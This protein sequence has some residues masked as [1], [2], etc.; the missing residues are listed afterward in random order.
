MITI[1][2]M[3]YRLVCAVL[4]VFTLIICTLLINSFI[5]DRRLRTIRRVLKDFQSSSLS[6]CPNK[7][8]N[9]I[10][11]PMLNMTPNVTSSKVTN[12]PPEVPS[13]SI[14][15]MKKPNAIP[16]MIRRMVVTSL[17]S[18][19]RV[20][21]WLR[22]LSINKEQNHMRQGLRRLRYMGNTHGMFSGNDLP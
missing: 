21:T 1:T 20:Y 5:L 3:A 11:S 17:F 2:E 12:T 14:V 13:F 10:T 19:R 18:I 7:F 16:I 4:I 22:G 9:S 6:L 15:K 8:I